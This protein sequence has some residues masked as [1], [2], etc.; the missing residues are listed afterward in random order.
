MPEMDLT[1]AKLKMSSNSSVAI[2]TVHFCSSFLMKC[3]CVLDL[4]I[5]LCK[6]ILVKLAESVH[7]CT[8]FYTDV[9]KFSYVLQYRELGLNSLY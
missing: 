1:W 6:H 5:Y 3:F 4:F 9:Y 8:C 2:V 7:L